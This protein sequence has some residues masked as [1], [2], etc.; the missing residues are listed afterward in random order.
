[1][2]FAPKF[3]RPPPVATRQPPL[4]KS[5]AELRIKSAAFTGIPTAPRTASASAP[6]STYFNKPR[7]E[8]DTASVR[9]R[10]KRGLSDDSSEEEAH[11]TRSTRSAKTPQPVKT[12]FVELSSSPTGDEKSS[13]EDIISPL[14]TT[15]RRQTRSMT[16]NGAEL[17]SNKTLLIY[18]PGRSAVTVTVSDVARLSDGEFLNDTLIEFYLRHL[19]Y[20]VLPESIVKQVHVFNSFLYQQLTNKDSVMHKT[21]ETRYER[22]RR[23]T[24]KLDIFKKRF[25][26]VPINEQYVFGDLFFFF[27]RLLVDKVLTWISVY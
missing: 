13:P 2:E 20:R 17:D 22:V 3:T 4:K 7:R 16:S 19:T 1:M 9:T 25:L 24:S 5:S 15:R 11:R 6:T 10:R 8:S 23:W 12:E 14:T 18:P 21:L 26:I 27:Q